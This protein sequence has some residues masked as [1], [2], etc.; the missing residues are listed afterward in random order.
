[1][2]SNLSEINAEDAVVTTYKAPVYKYLIRFS[3]IFTSVFF[4]TR[5]FFIYYKHICIK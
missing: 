2:L 4:I 3:F 1:M 5:I